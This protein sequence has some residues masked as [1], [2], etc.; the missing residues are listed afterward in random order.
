MP[1]DMIC[2]T[3]WQARQSCSTGSS[4]TRRKIALG[5][6]LS[7]LTATVGAQLPDLTFYGPS[8]NPQVLFRT[9]S[10]SDCEV[11]EGCAIAG[12]RRVLSF[13]GEIRNL[14]PSDLVIGDPS[15]NPLF[16]YAPCHGHYHFE[17]FAEYRLLDASSSLVRSGRKM[18][19]CL[20]DTQRWDPSANPN[21]RFHCGSQGLQAGWA[22]VYDPSVPCQWIDITGLP[23]GSYILEM[24]ID[25]GNYIP[26]ANEN[27]NATRVSVQIPGDCISSVNDLFANATTIS[28]SPASAEGN[29]GCASKETGEPNHAGDTGGVS[30][31][32]RWIA[33]SS[34]T[35]TITT[36]G[37]D[38]DTL[39]AVYTGS[40][41]G[42]LN[43]VA[44]ND[45]IVLY[46]YKQSRLTFQAVAGRVYSI[47][48][49]GW[50]GEHG[51]VQL[52][53]NPPPNDAFAECM[54]IS[55]TQGSV[56][57]YNTGAVKES[58]ERAH[59]GNIGGHSVW[60][61]WSAPAAGT[62][63]FDAVGSTFD[64]LLAIYTGSSVNAVT[65]VAANDDFGTNGASV[66]IFNA[67]AGVNY[68]IALD[69][70]AGQTGNYILSWAQFRRPVVS[71]RPLTPT[72]CEITVT[73]STGSYDLQAA[74]AIIGPWTRRASFYLTGTPFR[75]VEA[76]GP[77]F[78][79]YRVIALNP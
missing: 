1:D 31:W 45:D 69:G 2:T 3:S 27:N 26:E 60:F 35:T 72:Q 56:Q 34:A 4:L 58:N 54:T 19:F 49:D 75:Q 78:Q 28:G 38:F 64:T 22:D 10:T 11:V 50:Q 57:S 70:F 18:A 23:G 14:G 51:R 9:F 65:E 74:S 46:T 61:C 59:A 44:N 39:L 24:V 16:V 66:V 29:N 68:K 77:A 79:F 33:P 67:A 53:I 5:L 6:A 48:V 21:R 62:Y 8:A 63:V 7:T 12:T 15:N 36:I 13:T 42:S 17:Q 32:F 71:I 41:V 52:N 37:S 25:P 40:S 76:E 55:N 73:G 47:A 30:I 43:L 20:E